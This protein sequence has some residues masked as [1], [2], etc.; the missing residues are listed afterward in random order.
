MHCIV[1]M[2]RLL[3]ENQVSNYFMTLF[4]L[5]C[6][7]SIFLSIR[8]ILISPA[9]RISFA[10]GYLKANH[11][12]IIKTKGTPE[13]PW[14]ILLFLMQE[15]SFSFVT[16]STLTEPCR[17]Q[18]TMFKALLPRLHLTLTG[19]IF[20]TSKSL[21]AQLSVFSSIFMYFVYFCRDSSTF[22]NVLQYSLHR[23]QWW[24]E[25]KTVSRQSRWRKVCCVVDVSVIQ[26][27]IWLRTK[28][29]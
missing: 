17:L 3:F 20:G 7:A 23:W 13:H 16:L 4:S 24:C 19:V 28:E 10:S 27:S 9:K 1:L 8:S 18:V 29:L 12:Y 5:S 2:I 21:L 15:F 25:E 26:W 6:M 14:G 22:L 11:L